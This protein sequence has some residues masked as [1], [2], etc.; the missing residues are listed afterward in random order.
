LEDQEGAQLA[1]PY[2][3]DLVGEDVNNLKDAKGKPIFEEFLRIA[4]ERGSGWVD[5][6]WRKPGEQ[7]EFPKMTYIKRLPE[8]NMYVGVGCYQ[9]D[10]LKH[11]MSRADEN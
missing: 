9:S 2:R 4:E 1:H 7:G 11:G 6:W 3:P 10:E 5:Y 8:Y